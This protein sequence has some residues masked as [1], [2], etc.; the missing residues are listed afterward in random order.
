M[1]ASFNGMCALR[2]TYS[3]RSPLKVTLEGHSSDRIDVL[4]SHR[5]AVRSTDTFQLALA[6]TSVHTL[7]VNGAQRPRAVRPGNKDEL[8]PAKEDIEREGERSARF[9]AAHAK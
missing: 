2:T 1:R 6:W 3:S 5:T 8:C 9:E 4:L 7:Q